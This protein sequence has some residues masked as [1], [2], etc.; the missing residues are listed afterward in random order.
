MTL[1]KVNRGLLSKFHD[2][3]PPI[4]K[5]I[6]D[7][8]EEEELKEI[9]TEFDDEIDDEKYEEIYTID[10]SKEE[11]EFLYNEYKI[12][13]EDRLKNFVPVGYSYDKINVDKS[14][15]PLLFVSSDTG[16]KMLL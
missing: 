10:F 8:N 2:E 9:E 6:G 4:K 15:E 12:E 14:K 7:E 13:L 3:A 1:K 11:I 5:D 16:N